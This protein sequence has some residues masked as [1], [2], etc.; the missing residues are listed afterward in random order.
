M[1]ESLLLAMNVCLLLVVVADG[2]MVDG[3]GRLPGLGESASMAVTVI[4]FLAAFTAAGVLIAKG[5]GWTRVLAIALVAFY[6]VMLAPTV[7]P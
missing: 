4:V 5:H 2:F 3:N 6:L 7:M 1:K